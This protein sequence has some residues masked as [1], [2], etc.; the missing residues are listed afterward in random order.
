MKQAILLAFLLLLAPFCHSQP[1][2]TLRLL[3]AG[4]FEEAIEQTKGRENQY[5]SPIKYH[6][7]LARGYAQTGNDIEA[8]KEYLHAL[9]LVYKKNKKLKLIDFDVADELSLLRVRTGN[10]EGAR[11][12]INWSLKKRTKKWNRRNPTN[13]RPFLPLG[14]LH[15]SQANV[16]S[17]RYYLETYTKNLRNSNYTGH[18]DVDKYADAYQTMANITLLDG[19]LKKARLYA[20]KSSRLQRHPWTQKQVGKNYPDRVAALNTVTKINLRERKLKRAKNTDKRATRL[21]EK[22]LQGQELIRA[23]VLLSKAHLAF[24]T[25]DLNKARANLRGVMEL[26]VRYIKTTF[27]Y[28]SEYE[29]QNAHVAF[30]RN[31]AEVL[32]LAFEVLTTSE[33]ISEDPLAKDVFNFIINTKSVILS[34]SNKL[35]SEANSNSSLAKQLRTWKDLKRQWYYLNAVATKKSKQRANEVQLEIV[36]VEKILGSELGIE[37]AKNWEAIAKNLEPD[38]LAIEFAKIRHRDSTATF[39]AFMV[40]K[41]SRAPEVAVLKSPIEEKQF[42]SYYSNSIRFNQEDTLTHSRFWKPLKIKNTVKK[43][44]LSPSGVL[45]KVNFSTL[46]SFDQRFIADDYQLVNISNTGNLANTQ[47]GIGQ[48]HT[49]TLIGV[50]DFKNQAEGSQTNLPSLPGVLSEIREAS[51]ILSSNNIKTRRILDQEAKKDTLSA[52]PSQSILHLATHGFFDSNAT[53]PMLG[54]G[55][56]FSPGKQP[57]DAILTAYEASLLNLDKTQ[58]VV[59]SAC[60]SGLGGIVDGEGVYGLQRAFQVAGVKNIIMSLWNIDDQFTRYFMTTFYSKLA[61]TADVST[62]FQETLSKAKELNPNPRFWGAFKLVQ[63]F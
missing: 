39:L 7:F 42:I 17:A 5:R 62:A 22:H 2:K 35:I 52:L 24:Q 41:E 47:E 12:L 44:Y 37:E 43:I 60:A 23:D 31:N 6:L 50:S 61:N 20:N 25:N 51:S 63:F 26:K 38:E 32:A 27:A 18:L 54:S 8:E 46:R 33:T 11:V 59:L 36:R 40:E 53:N 1:A 4:K 48:F 45:H 16:D 58:L 13:F 55:L 34:E 15:F 30:E 57:S 14:I 56:I 28:L 9:D 29:K 19:D 3:K 49:A 21:L 10:W